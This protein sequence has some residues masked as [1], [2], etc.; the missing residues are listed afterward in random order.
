M[1]HLGGVYEGGEECLSACRQE[2]G[3]S[4]CEYQAR[5]RTCYIHTGDVATGSG[6]DG[7]TCYVLQQTGVYL[8]WRKSVGCS[9]CIFVK[10][11]FRIIHI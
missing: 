4:G 10:L 2:E 6:D 9:D 1:R 11:G 5:D 3:A 7:Y 8:L